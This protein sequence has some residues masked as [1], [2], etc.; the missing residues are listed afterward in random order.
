MISEPGAALPLLFEPVDFL[1][2][3]P[4]YLRI[5]TAVQTTSVT[6]RQK[7]AWFAWVE[8]RLRLLVLKLEDVPTVGQI[9][10]W[11]IRSSASGGGI[12][13]NIGLVYTEV[14][15]PAAPLTAATLKDVMDNFVELVCAG[16]TQD[17]Q[18]TV[19]IR[20]VT[21]AGDVVSIGDDAATV[22]EKR[23]NGV[24]LISS[25]VPSAATTAE[26]EQP[27]LKKAKISV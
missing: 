1:H 24:P 17:I 7:E 21:G 20:L 5:S 22:G 13:F 10:P 12:D 9:R 2:D 27:P 3:Y 23:R 6:E 15:A 25:N 19:T 14:C 16:I 18:Q 26:A 4:H 8:S 11:P